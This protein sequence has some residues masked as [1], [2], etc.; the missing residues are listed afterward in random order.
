MRSEAG[1]LVSGFGDD[2]LYGAEVTAGSLALR[3]GS[4][5]EDL[6]DMCFALREVA[7]EAVASRPASEELAALDLAAA[8]VERNREAFLAGYHAVERTAGL[9]PTDAALGAAL[10]AALVELRV[11][12]YEAAP[13][14]V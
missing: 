4:P 13:A 8:W 14:A 11:R 5:L 7:L 1:W 12:R 3:N 10:L 6:A 9:L 2:P